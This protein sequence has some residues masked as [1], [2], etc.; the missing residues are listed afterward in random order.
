MSL[1]VIAVGLFLATIVERLFE[2]VISKR[3]AAWSFAR[4]AVE[5][6]ANHYKWMVLMHTAFLVSMLFEFF[7]LGSMVPAYV[8]V[9]AMVL[10]FVCQGFRWWIIVTLGHQWNTRVIIIPGMKR[11]VSG[12]YRF[13]NHPNYVVVAIETIAL[14]LIFGAWRTAFVFSVLNAAMM[15][16]RIRVENR[17]LRELT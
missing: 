13:L 10:A 6:G 16:V 15:I 9:L 5:Y 12:P 8:Q 7:T 1:D 14:P 4:G 17:A 2:L 3:N 11:V